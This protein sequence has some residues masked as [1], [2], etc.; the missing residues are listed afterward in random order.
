MSES[1]SEMTALDAART[2]GIDLNRLYVLL[3]MGRLEG[4]KVDGVWRVSHQAVQ[5]RLQSRH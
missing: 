1:V 5:E 2:L 3:R 4:R